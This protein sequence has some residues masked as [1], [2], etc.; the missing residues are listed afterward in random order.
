MSKGMGNNPMESYEC[1]KSGL[2]AKVSQQISSDLLP[3]K[4]G[5]I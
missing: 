4:L 5:F 1:P 3:N 2:R